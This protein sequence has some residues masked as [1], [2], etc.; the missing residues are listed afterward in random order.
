[1]LICLGTFTKEIPSLETY[2][3]G[4]HHYVDFV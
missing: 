1:M 4:E 3:N 2:T